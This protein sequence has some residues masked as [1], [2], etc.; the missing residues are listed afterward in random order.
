MPTN[1]SYSLRLLT[2]APEDKEAVDKALSIFTSTTAPDMRTD[3]QQIEYKIKK[4]KTEEGTFYFAAF[5]REQDLIGFVMFGHYPGS[6]LIVIDHIAIDKEK[7]KQAA[8]YEFVGL[9]DTEFRN[10]GLDVDFVAVEVENRE[11]TD[12]AAGGREFVQLLKWIGFCEVKTDYFL[13]DMDVEGH[14]DHPGIL[15]LKP[16]VDRAD[17]SGSQLTRIYRSILFDHYFPWYRDFLAKEQID[18]YRKYLDGLYKK[19][20]DRVEKLPSIELGGVK[21]DQPAPSAEKLTLIKTLLA[22]AGVAIVIA[23]FLLV[24][25]PESDKALYF[26][27]ALVVVF[28]GLMLI[29]QGRADH[30]FNSVLAKLPSAEIKPRSRHG[31]RSRSKKGDE[32]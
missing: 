31:V 29:A 9:L 22:F 20:R 26:I 25:K 15:M 2:S 27:L 4:P 32:D 13:A 5:Y 19:F 30:V 28:A 17:I 24:V 1:V 18:A 12:G 6:R 3:R 16:S 7:R 11:V 23:A 10:L 21:P 14:S 8:F